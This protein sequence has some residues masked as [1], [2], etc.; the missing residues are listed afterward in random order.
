M[1]VIQTIA[2]ITKDGKLLVPGTV[3]LPAGDY[4]VVIVIDEKQV[5]ASDI[6]M[7]PFSA[8]D[9]GPIDENCTFRREDLYDDWGR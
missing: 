8:Y 5:T 4:T 1:K 3:S 6:G 9:V 7:L 2:T